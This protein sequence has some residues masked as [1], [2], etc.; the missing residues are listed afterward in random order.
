MENLLK[1]LMIKE[2]LL[3]GHLGWMDGQVSAKTITL[4]TNL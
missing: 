3:S 4:I 2:I 1:I